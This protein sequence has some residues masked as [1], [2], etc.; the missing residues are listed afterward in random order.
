MNP[1]TVLGHKLREFWPIIILMAGLLL[2]RSPQHGLFR[3][4]PCPRKM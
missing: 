1:T 4:R 2:A 3:A